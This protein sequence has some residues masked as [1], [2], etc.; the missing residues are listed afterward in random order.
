MFHLQP[1]KKSQN[2]KAKINKSSNKKPAQQARKS[3]TQTQ[4]NHQ[5][6]ESEALQKHKTKQKPP[7]THFL[8]VYHLHCRKNLKSKQKP[9]P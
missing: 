2:P 8:T 6:L 3:R 5:K 4:S 7:K 1:Q 9:K